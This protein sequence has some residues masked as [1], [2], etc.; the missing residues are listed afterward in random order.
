[1]K[2]FRS[3]RWRLQ[4]WYALLLASVLSGFG[5]AAYEIE[6][7][8]L[9]RSTDAELE[10]RVTLITRGLRNPPPPNGAPRRPPERP[11][12]GGD[13]DEPPR[14]DFGPP[15]PPPDSQGAEPDG[16]SPRQNRLGL[17]IPPEDEANYEAEGAGKWYYAIWLRN[18]P[19]FTR[20]TNAPAEIPR[21]F[22]LARSRPQG[23]VLRTR[24]DF[25]EAFL[26]LAPG[27]LALV[28]HDLS[29]DILHLHHLG[30]LMASAAG[31][32][33]ALALVG[34]HWLIGRSLKPIAEIS[35]A[36]TKIAA[37]NLSQRIDPRDT[38]SELGQLAQVLDATFARLEASFAQQARFTADAAHELRTPLSVLLT[39]IQNALAVECASEE[40]HEALA[41]CQRAAQRMRALTESLLWLAR[42]DSGA[43]ILKTIRFDLARRT[44]DCVELIRPLAERRGIVLRAD[45][46]PAE[47]LGDPEQID[48]VVTNL[49][50][51]AIEHNHEKGEIRL[52]TRSGPEGV[53]LILA[54]SGPGI[55][56][57][58]LPHVFDRF[59]RADKSRTRS[60]GGIG[61]GLAIAKAIAEAHGGTIAV[62]SELGRGATFIVRFP[63]PSEAA[64]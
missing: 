57:T 58:D 14:N 47:C 13:G 50:T 1:M 18:G 34:G 7:T 62:E 4:F 35:A 20:S 5:L 41:A 59:Y 9:V 32:I 3:I 15:P 53:S 43:Q 17:R 12:R 64:R 29:A 11:P 38:D 61:L 54:D 52:A 46:N 60:S 45:L 51:N 39:H 16:N 31:M 24:G 44:A 8:D 49:L 2:A 28:G 56:P 19:P 22:P 33:L 30:W 36:A 55:A 25:R 10:R 21:P 27:D 26:P 23:P 40:H 6:R 63:V 37:G 48:Q 42:L